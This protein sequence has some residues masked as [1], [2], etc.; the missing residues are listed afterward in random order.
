MLRMKKYF[1][2]G[3]ASLLLPMLAAA[4]VIAEDAWIPLAPPGTSTYAGYLRL[5]N[6]G[7]AE[8]KIVGVSSDAFAQVMIH[9]TVQENGTARME[10]MDELPLPAGKVIRFEPGGLHVMFVGAQQPI[11]AERPVML[12]LELDDGSMLDVAFAVRPR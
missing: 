4:A 7:D 9:R 11:N 6:R 3:V 5:A 2:I 8:R 12:R 1:V 10:H